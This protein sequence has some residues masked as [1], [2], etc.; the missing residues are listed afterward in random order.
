MNN[1][2]FKTQ[3]FPLFFSLALCI[4]SLALLS[5]VKKDA[6]TAQ[7]QPPALSKGNNYRIGVVLPLSG[8]YQVYGEST[9]HGIECAAGIF[10]PCEAPIKA[11][12][13]I[14]DDAGLPDRAAAAVEE[15][16]TRDKVNIIIG[17]LSSSSVEAA[18]RKAQELQVPLISLS[19]KEGVTGIGDF[20]FGISLT[21]A[22][23][24]NTIAEWATKT[25]KLKTFSIIYP[26]NTY[27]Q[28]YKQ[29]FTSAVSNAKGRV[30]SVN[31]YGETTLD[32]TGLFEKGIV[33]AD[34]MFIPDSYRAVGYI[35]SY[36]PAEGGDRTQLLGVNRWNNPELAE[37]AGDAV[38]GAVFVDG[39]FDSS[40]SPSV[41]KFVGAFREA[42]GLA[43]TILESQGFDAARL[44]L[45][46]LQLTGGGHAV[47]VRNS[48]LQIPE[49]D[50]S[51]G[52]VSFGQDREAQKRLFLLTVK[53]GA[54][55]EFE[56]PN[57]P[58]PP[59]KDKYGE[60]IQSS[61]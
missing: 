29:L 49:V 32:F 51:T 30:V 22:A 14:K 47:D 33:K 43:P 11:E 26:L 9:L 56:G 48:L 60:S 4:F 24:V 16:A 53:N 40:R 34:A 54:I 10:S 42:Y 5:C 12:L 58:A 37:L 21:A 25:K 61:R 3:S 17:P 45:K 44:A 50:G 18:A 38:E 23:Q 6:S 59:K 2:K 52:G 41:Q 39:F 28:T 19:Q 20:I 1:A 13:V 27:G 15:L 31:S 55:V 8:K 46:S 57:A 35:A 36:L 7:G